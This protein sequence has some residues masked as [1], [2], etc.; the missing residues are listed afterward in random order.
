MSTFVIVDPET[1]ERVARAS[2]LTRDSAE[3][4]IG[5]WMERYILGLRPDVPA[6]ALARLEVR[7]ER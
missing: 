2:F 6:N 7:E 5:V 1:G 3:R 4:H